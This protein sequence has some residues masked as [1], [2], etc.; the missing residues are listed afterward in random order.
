MSIIN[1]L[2]I[3]T[4]GLK[5]VHIMRPL[6]FITFMRGVRVQ[7]LSWSSSICP[8][9]QNTLT[10]ANK[11]H[12]CPI[13]PQWKTSIVSRLP[14]LL[15][16]RPTASMMLPSLPKAPWLTF[17]TGSRSRTTLP[18]SWLTL[19]AWS[20]TRTADSPKAT[21]LDPSILACCSF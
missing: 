15:I 16:Q 7:D 20:P 3:N 1:P 21:M 8:M 19:P 2:Y 14:F 11:M 17:L 18:M 12:H 5:F 4:V 9:C 6:T 13:P 10:E